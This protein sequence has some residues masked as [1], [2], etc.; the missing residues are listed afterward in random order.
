[1]PSSDD[2]KSVKSTGVLTMIRKQSCMVATNQLDT[3]CSTQRATPLPTSFLLL[4]QGTTGKSA[5]VTTSIND[6]RPYNLCFLCHGQS[7]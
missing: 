1:M 2:V 4:L 6:E 3:V 5:A 7:T